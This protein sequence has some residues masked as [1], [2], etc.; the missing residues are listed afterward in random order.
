MKITNNIH[1][2]LLAVV[3]NF[4]FIAL[5]SFS[6][7]PEEEVAKAVKISLISKTSTFPS[8]KRVEKKQKISQNKNSINKARTEEPIEEIVDNDISY[9]PP[10]YSYGSVN[11]PIPKYPKLAIRKKHQGKVIV[12]VDVSTNGLVSSA[13]I[14]NSS[15]SNLL[16]RAALK[17]IRYWKFEAAKKGNEFVIAKIQI[18]I[19]F[20]LNKS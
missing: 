14:C 8:Q 20:S 11:N 19:I 18:P 9:T 17:T 1:N 6:S 2:I 16:D 4:A 12:C 10:L 13:S 15:G 7:I 3:I 5:F